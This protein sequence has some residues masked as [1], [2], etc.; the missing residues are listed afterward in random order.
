M[1]LGHILT[2]LKIILLIL[3]CFVLNVAHTTDY[4]ISSQQKTK[5]T[6]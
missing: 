6:T 5:W 1:Y 3:T 4:Y 2:L